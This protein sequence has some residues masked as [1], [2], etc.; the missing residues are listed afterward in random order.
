VFCTI[1]EQ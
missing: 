1:Y